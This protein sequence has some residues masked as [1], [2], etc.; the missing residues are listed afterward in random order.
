[1]KTYPWRLG[2]LGPLACAALL[3]L[4]I[5]AAWGQAPA[6]VSLDQNGV[7]LCTNLQPGSVARVKWAASVLGPWQADEPGFEAI[8]VADDGTIRVV[9]PVG[10]EEARF[11]RVHGLGRAPL[12]VPAALVWLPPGT[13]RMGSPATELER[14]SN[15][16]PQTLVTLSQG[17]FI[18]KYEVTQG[19]YLAL[20]GLNPSAWTGDPGFPVEQVSW[21]DATNYCARLTD[22]ERLAGR[23]PSNWVYR[24]PT[25]A[26]WEFACRAGGTNVFSYGEALRSGE[27]SFDSWY[28]Y[29]A[30]QGTVYN[31][32]GMSVSWPTLAGIY[33]PNDWNLYD[34]HGNVWEW[35]QDWYGDSLPGGRVTDPTGAASGSKRVMRGGGAFSHAARCRSAVRESAPPD[36]TRYDVGFRVVLAPAG[37]GVNH[38]QVERPLTGR[39]Q[40]P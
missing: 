34:M 28:E 38:G 7:L 35:C 16:G 1:M 29:E 18:A 32:Y 12:P 14:D 3:A 25:E 24:L 19:D 30:T 2:L 37:F 40:T 4:P 6:V 33:L 9:L 23:L 21:N 26:E 27:A 11:F 22:R 31:P 5:P 17:F 36:A 15:E 39:V 8:P 10:L 13:F 20:T